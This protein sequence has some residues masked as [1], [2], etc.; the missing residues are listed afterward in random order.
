MHRDGYLE[1][2]SIISE[3]GRGPLG[4]EKFLPGA[5]GDVSKLD[6][7]LTVQHRRDRAISRTGHGLTLIDS[8]KRLE[9]RADLPQTTEADDALENVKSG[10]FK[11]LSIEFAAREER[12]ESGIRVVSSAF[13]G[14]VSVVDTPAYPRQPP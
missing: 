4:P 14:G 2:R 12:R 5:F 8:E 3:V 9:V 10:I 1:W 6:L 11:G 7:L 13:L